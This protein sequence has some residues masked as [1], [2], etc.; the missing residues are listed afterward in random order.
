MAPKPPL[1]GKT[2]TKM[3]KFYAEG[4]CQ[5][6]GFCTFAHSEE[7]IGTDWT[8]RDCRWK[9]ALCKWWEADGSPY[10]N[11]ARVT[12]LWFGHMLMLAHACLYECVVYRPLR[13][14]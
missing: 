6:Q 13:A 2:I 7:E 10:V 8:D 5:R 9:L 1:T 4:Y 12:S 14:R 11:A 3:C